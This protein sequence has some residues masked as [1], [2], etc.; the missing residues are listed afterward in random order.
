MVLS[1]VGGDGID[2]TTVR[3]LL[4][5][6][7]LKKKEIQRKVLA[8]QPVT[9]A[10]WRPGGSVRAAAPP[11][12]P[13]FGQGGRG[14]RGRRSVSRTPRQ[15]CRRPCDHAAHVPA[16]LRPCPSVSVPRQ[17][18]GHSSYGTDGFVLCFSWFWVHI[19]WLHRYLRAQSCGLD[20]ELTHAGLR[21]QKTPPPGRGRESLQS[22]GRRKVTAAGGTSQGTVS[23][24]SACRYWLGCWESK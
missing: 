19:P 1:L 7:A 3:F 24:P 9:D 20:Y 8:E 5:Q 17:S 2:D 21:A 6:L 14:K 22:P 11:P 23:Q 18:V 15:G 10:D 16:V 12:H 4:L 13:L